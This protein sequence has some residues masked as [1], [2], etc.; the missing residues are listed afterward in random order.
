VV[1]R[2]FIFGT[3][4]H[5]RIGEC[6]DGCWGIRVFCSVAVTSDRL[7]CPDGVNTVQE[8]Q[9]SIFDSRVVQEWLSQ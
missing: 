2:V 3:E 9:F 7:L 4:M 6:L 5:R 8:D 1:V